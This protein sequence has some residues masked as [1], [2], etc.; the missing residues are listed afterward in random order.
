MPSHPI[1]TLARAMNLL[2]TTKPTALKAIGALVKAGILHET[3]GK[4]RDRVFAY[5]NY[6]QVLMRDT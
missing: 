4:E 1:V 6:L 5:R 2:H 3:T